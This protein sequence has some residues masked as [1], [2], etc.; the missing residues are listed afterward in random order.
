MVGA[1]R[2][3]LE[4]SRQSQRNII[5]HQAPLNFTYAGWL[6]KPGWDG[7]KQRFLQKLVS[8]PSQETEGGRCTILTRR[9]IGIG[10]SVG[11]FPIKCLSYVQLPVYDSIAM[12]KILSLVF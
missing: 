11:E 9:F 8:L 1:I 10:G 7:G 2:I 6:G 12:A 4:F 5:R 3:C